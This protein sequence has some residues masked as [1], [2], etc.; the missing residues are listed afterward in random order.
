MTTWRRQG[1]TYGPVL[2]D[3]YGAE[4]QYVHAVQRAG[5]Q[6]FLAPEP[7]PGT[8]P[9]DTIL[10]FDGLLLIGGEDLSAEVSS[11]DPDDV[12]ANA[13]ADRDRWEMSLIGAALDRDLAVFAVCRGMQ[14]LNVALGGTLHGDIADSSVE[15]P[16]VPLELADALAFRHEIEVLPESI[17][18]R[19]YGR[20]STQVNSLHHQA[21]DRVAAPLAVIARAKD[22][23]VE[24]VELPGAHWCLGVQWHPE[25]MPQDPPEQRLFTAFVD[26][27]E[28]SRTHRTS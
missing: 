22:G 5:A 7:T 19:N 1:R 11:V 15:H 20:A 24:A 10:G 2:R 6:V 25:L 4:A 26:A 13:S 27:A 28:T 8:D 12:G 3:M 23:V 14:L 9:T 16:S 18:A 17:L 21:L